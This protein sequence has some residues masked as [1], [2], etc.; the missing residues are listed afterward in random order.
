MNFALALE[1]AAV[2]AYYTAGGGFEN[3]ALAQAAASIVGV[4]ATHVAILNSAL[5]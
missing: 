2:G 4:E 3:R 1:S 5:K